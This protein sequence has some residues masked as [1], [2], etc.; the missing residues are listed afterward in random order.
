VNTVWRAISVAIFLI[1]S[2]PSHARAESMRGPAHYGGQRSFGFGPALGVYAGMGGLVTLKADPI[3]VAVSGGYMPVLVVGND[4]ADQS[5]TFDYYGSGQLNA[6]V[7]IG[8]L[9]T[10]RKVDVDLLFGYRYNTLLGNGVGAGVRFAMDVSRTLRLEFHWSPHFFPR[11]WHR[12]EEEGYPDDRTPSL[13]WFQ[14]G[15]GAAAVFYP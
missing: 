10:G 13:P 11:A 12:L 15:L 8:P 1:I 9:Y 5:I 3:G 6:D 7:L 4:K 14:G 2:R